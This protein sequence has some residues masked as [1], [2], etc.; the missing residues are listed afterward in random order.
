MSLKDDVIQ[1]ERLPIRANEAQYVESRVKGG[2][3]QEEKLSD[4]AFGKPESRLFNM[5]GFVGNPYATN[6]FLKTYYQFASSTA[7]ICQVTSCIPA[8]QFKDIAAQASICGR[9]R[10]EYDSPILVV[11]EAIDSSPVVK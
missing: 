10:R 5:F 9:K 6:P 11:D 1:N 4:K 3:I 7:T 8:N 2:G